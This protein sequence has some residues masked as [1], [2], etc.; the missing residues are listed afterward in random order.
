MAR[1]VCFD[2]RLVPGGGAVEMAISNA[3]AQKA[4]KFQ[5]RSL[6]RSPALC[7]SRFRRRVQPS[8]RLSW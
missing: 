7:I 6:E 5:V 1:N 2:P 8:T 3:L 4:S